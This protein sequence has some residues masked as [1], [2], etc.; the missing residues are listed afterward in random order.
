MQMIVQP[1]EVLYINRSQAID[2]F[3]RHQIQMAKIPKPHGLEQNSNPNE[4]QAT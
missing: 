2:G 3:F 4:L 1:Q